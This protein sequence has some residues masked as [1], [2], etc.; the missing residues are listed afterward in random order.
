M[1]LHLPVLWQHA[2]TLFSLLW[3]I[4]LQLDRTP[5]QICVSVFQVQDF[6]SYE[7]GLN[8]AVVLSNHKYTNHPKYSDTCN[9]TSQRQLLLCKTQGFQSFRRAY[10]N[11]QKI[12]WNGAFWQHI[13][14][15]WYCIQKFLWHEKN[16]FK[17]VMILKRIYDILL[18]GR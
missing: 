13:E 1:F 5:F 6:F 12:L 4:P 17:K 3:H 15:K 8:T 2:R 7:F 10:Q 14:S 11:S 9:A 16:V 18:T